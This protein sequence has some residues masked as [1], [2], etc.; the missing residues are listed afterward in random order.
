[1]SDADEIAEKV[2]YDLQGTCNSLL[3]QLEK[4]DREDLE[5]N[6]QFC[7]RLDSMVFECSTCNW[8][9]EVSEMTND[10]EHDWNCTDCYPDIE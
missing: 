2:A 5:M 10:P 4:I 3:S 8:W 9:C 1:M 7:A 6:D